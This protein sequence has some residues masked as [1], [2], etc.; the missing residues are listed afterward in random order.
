VETIQNKGGAY[1]GLPEEA[2][3]ETTSCPPAFLEYMWYVILA[4]AMLG[5]VW[6]VV[7]PSVGGMLLAVLAATCFLSV[8]TQASR[9]YAPVALALLTGFSVIAVQFI[10]HS[11]RSFDESI[12]FV[13]WLL[14][15]IIVQALSSRRGFLKRFALASFAI[16][17]GVLPYV[18][19]GMDSRFTR[20]MATGTGISNP[21]ALG[22]WFGFCTVYFVFLGMQFR[23][24]IV[25]AVCWSAGLGSLFVAALTVSRAPLLG[26]A[27]A[28]VVGL[29]SALKSYF[30]PLL[31][32]LILLL[33]VHL[34]GAFQETIDHFLT[35][36]MEESGRGKLWP[37]ALERLINSL[38]TGV[39]LEATPTWISSQSKPFNPHNGPLYIGL[40]AGIF[41]LICFLAYLARAGTGAFH[42]LQR[43][44]VGETA[45]IPPL[46]TFAIIEVMTLDFAFMSQWS[47]VVFGL[48]A[49]KRA[50][51][52]EI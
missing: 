47:V 39:G 43:G 44:Y 5:Q 26:V 13:G 19:A 16:G 33:L 30:I 14:N 17:L 49:A 51:V 12:V 1:A 28:F 31:S 4:Y 21:N 41:P 50:S 38:W 52:H 6:G 18:Q 48:A 15:L 10:F 25:R 9:V 11:A 42:M 45:L 32:F 27:L 46:V 36:G 23:E 24:H 20:A 2:V 7:I 37:V 8:V 22:M 34:S 29:R 3:F 35:R 40:G